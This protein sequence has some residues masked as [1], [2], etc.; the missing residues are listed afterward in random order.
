MNL[1]AH[2]WPLDRLA[3]ALTALAESHG[4]IAEPGGASFMLADPVRWN[5]CAAA[6][7]VASAVASRPA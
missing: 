5:S 6:A 1:L 3:A 2:A 7:T 4:L